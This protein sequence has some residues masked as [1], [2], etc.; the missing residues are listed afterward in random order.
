MAIKISLQSTIIPVEIGDLKF[1]V[2]I[3]DKNNKKNLELGEKMRAEIDKIENLE[4]E[5]AEK[6]EKATLKVI[7][8]SFDGLL[9]AGAFDQIYGLLPSVTL[10]ADVFL[11]LMIGVQEETAKKF[12]N[13]KFNKYLDE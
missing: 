7:K 10:M 8:E 2:N 12:K 9:G 5:K 4:G 13:D 3:D 6:A 1:E 11:E